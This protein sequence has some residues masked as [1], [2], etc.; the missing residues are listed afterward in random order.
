MTSLKW[1]IGEVEIFQIIELEAGKLIQSIIKKATAEN[2]QNIGWLSPYFADEAGGLKALVQSF[3][4]RSNNKNIL[5]DTCNGN[6][7]VRTDVPEWANLQTN[8]LKKLTAVG[9]AETNIDVVACTHL[10]MDHIGWNT[11]LKGGIWV[12]TFPTLKDISGNYNRKLRNFTIFWDLIQQG[13][14][15]HFCGQ[16]CEEK[17]NFGLK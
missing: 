1:K 4:V 15:S 14:L 3:L 9:V 2:I 5:I 16:K 10:H 6:D 8:F 12:P 7:K 13:V 11:K 17:T